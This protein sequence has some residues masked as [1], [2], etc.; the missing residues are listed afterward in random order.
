MYAVF[1]YIT[2]QLDKLPLAMNVEEKQKQEGYVLIVQDG[3][4]NLPLISMLG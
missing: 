3:I 4:S 1:F 2:M